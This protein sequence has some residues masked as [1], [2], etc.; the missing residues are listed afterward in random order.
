MSIEMWTG[1]IYIY[2]YILLLVHIL[3]LKKLSITHTELIR[4]YS[5]QSKRV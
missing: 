2:T 4:E 5:A 3:N 1:H